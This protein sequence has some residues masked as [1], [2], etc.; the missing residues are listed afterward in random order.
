MIVDPGPGLYLGPP[1]QPGTHYR[2]G[3]G[4]EWAGIRRDLD[5]DG[6]PSHGR[7]R[8][9]RAEPGAARPAAGRSNYTYSNSEYGQYSS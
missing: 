2:P 9:D 1:P 7:R 8:N 6:D 3:P 4:A 5:S